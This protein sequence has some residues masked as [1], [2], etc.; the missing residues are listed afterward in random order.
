VEAGLAGLPVVTTRVDGI[1]EIVEDGRSGFLVPPR[2][3]H[4]LAEALQ[5][6]LG[7]AVLRERMGKEGRTIALQ[8]FTMERIASRVADLYRELLERKVM[9]QLATSVPDGQILDVGCGYQPYRCLFKT[10]HYL[11]LDVSLERRPTVVGDARF[12]PFK[13]SVFDG[14]ICSEVIEHIFDF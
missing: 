14:I 13:D 9:Q 7:D 11:G 10:S 4:A 1:V 2:D 6:L 3:S 12:L 8:R 5:A